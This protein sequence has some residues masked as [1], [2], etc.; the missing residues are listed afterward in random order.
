MSLGLE[1]DAPSGGDILPIIKFNATSGEFLAVNREQQAD[2]T[3]KSDIVEQ[4]LPFKFIMDL[5]N[6]EVGWLSFASGAPDFVMVRIGEK[7]PA[8][9]T[10]DHKKAF[11]VRLY[12]KTLGMRVFSSS[13]K[14]VVR[15]M[16]ALHNKYEA[17]RGANAGKLPVIEV[18][19]CETVK[20]ATPQGELRFKAP[21][22]KIVSW[23]D[24]PGVFGDSSPAEDPAPQSDPTP[25]DDNELF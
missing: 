23:V 8:Q 25:T 19:K 21:V 16:E 2:G 5:E 12:N 4:E 6:I 17:E 11:R 10:E 22:W 13:A 18:P 7:K 24:D 1:I 3:W 20:I 15:T 14:T 9:P